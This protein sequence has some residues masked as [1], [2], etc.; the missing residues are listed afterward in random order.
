MKFP[1]TLR[2]LGHL[3]RKEAMKAD[4]GR[5]SLASDHVK[6]LKVAI[7]LLKANDVPE[8]LRIIFLKG[9]L[10][11]QVMQEPGWL[12]SWVGSVIEADKN[13]FD[14]IVFRV[15]KDETRP[16]HPSP[17][18]SHTVSAIEWFLQKRFPNAPNSNS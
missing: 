11:E 18:I 3:L 8:N 17:K 16:G 13:N 1:Y 4:T 6:E 10:T 2:K 7:E 12:Q 15:P 9:W 14:L 5:D